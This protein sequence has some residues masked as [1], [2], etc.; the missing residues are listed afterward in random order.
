MKK[1][2][3]TV[4]IALGFVALL[5][6]AFINHNEAYEAGIARNLFTGETTLQ[7]SGYNLTAFWVQVAHMDTRPTR[8][9]V[10]T[11]A[12]AFNC[13]LVQFEPG[14]WR[15]FIAVQGF[16]Y[17]WWANRLSFNWGYD[18]EYRGVRDLLRGYGF[19]VKKYKFTTVLRD[20]SDE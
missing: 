1:F 8:V 16:R 10:T 9:C 14:A 17:Y 13:R 4:A 15:E 2:I 11:T 3:V 6:L 20:Y 18:E 7:S 19:G 12:R 5:Y